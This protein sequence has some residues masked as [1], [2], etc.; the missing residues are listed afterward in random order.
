[1]KHSRLIVLLLLS[2]TL[3]AGLIGVNRLE[4]D[5]TADFDANRARLLSYVL[6]EQLNRNHYS[7]RQIDDALSRDAFGLYLEQLDSQ[8]R[9]LLTADVAALRQNELKIDDELKAGR[10]ELPEQSRVIFR[11][12]LAQVRTMVVELIAKGF[13]TDL[14]ESIETDADKLTYADSLEVLRD[15]WRRILKYQTMSRFLA[16]KEEAVAEMKEGET[17]DE[18]KLLEE[19]AGKIL[20]SFTSYFDRLEQDTERD[21]YDRYFN[22]VTRAFDP[23]TNYFPPQQKEDFDISM[24]GSLEGIGALLREEEG[25]IKVERVIPGSAAARQG[26]LLA[27][28]VI[29]SVGESA[30]EPVDITDMRLRDAVALIRGPKGTEVR[31]TVR[32]TTGDRKLIPIVRDV[33][34]IEDAFVKHTLRTVDGKK[35]GYVHI[36]TFYRDFE[37]SRNGESARNSTDDTRVAVEALKKEKIDGLV[38]DLRNNGGGAL[39]DAVS[40]AGLFIDKGPVVQV[41]NSYDKVESL[42]DDIPGTVYDGPMIVLVNEFSASASEILAAALQDYGRAVIVGSVHTHGKGTVQTLIDLDRALSF[43]NMAKY[44]PLGALK[45]TTQ[46]FYRVSGGSTQYRGVEP[47]IVLPDL[48]AYLK[49]GE[50]HIDFSLPWDTIAAVPHDRWGAGLD[51]G[52]LKARSSKRTTSDSWFADIEQD[53]LEAKKKSEATKQSLLLADIVRERAQAEEE[54]KKAELSPHDTSADAGPDDNAWIKR[55][56]DDHYL[57]EAE[58]ILRDILTAG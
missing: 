56:D 58:A 54:R 38:V 33:V 47:D 52:T 39:T 8:K 7:H 46:K 13:K 53:A 45:L 29:L 43:G 49:T 1:M 14:V 50:K 5:D 2:L 17:I 26:D 48:L 12:R 18:A 25:Y 10:I 42:N 19:A 11:Q 3:T 30:Q 32:R 15:R 27:G 35:F 21:F 34:Q 36:P 41:R 40:I 24:R 20:K 16:M 55:L 31:L 28:D 44:K 22:A 6:R 23:H 4:A 51:I 37:G 9:F 57:K